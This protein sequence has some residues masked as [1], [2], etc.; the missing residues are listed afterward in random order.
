VLIERPVLLLVEKLRQGQ[1]EGLPWGILARRCPGVAPSPRVGA[2]GAGGWGGKSAAFR[3]PAETPP[4]LGCGRVGVLGGGAEMTAGWGSLEGS[5][6]NTQLRSH[7]RTSRVEAQRLSEAQR[8]G[9]H[10][11]E[12]P[13]RLWGEPWVGLGTPRP[14]CRPVGAGPMHTRTREARPGKPRR[15][16]RLRPCAWPGRGGGGGLSSPSPCGLHGLEVLP[17]L[18]TSCQGLA[19]PWAGGGGAVGRVGLSVC[20]PQVGGLVWAGRGRSRRS[21]QMALGHWPQVSGLHPL[22]QGPASLRTLDPRGRQDG[23]RVGVDDGTPGPGC[24]EQELLR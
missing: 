5:P 24:P 17:G 22:L 6:A 1:Q 14:G 3:P 8:G 19:P 9:R 13:A 15:A 18:P 11:Q 2:N 7:K 16:L 12:S 21:R 20:P 4:T 23:G 10:F